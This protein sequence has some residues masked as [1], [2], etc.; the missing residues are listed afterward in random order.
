MVTGSDT[1]AFDV[2]VIGGGSAGYA[3]ARATAE[4]ALKTVVIDGGPQLGG[5]CILR[6]C[7]PTKAL[8]YASEVKHLAEH[9][10]NW[11]LQVPRVGF[12]FK[13]VMERKNALIEDFASYRRD[14]LQQG[15]FELIRSKARFMDPNT[16]A[17][18]NG[19]TLRADSILISTGSSVAPLPLPALTAAAPWTS[20]EVLN[21]SRLPESI[22]VLGGGPVALEL[23]QFFLR[24]GVRTTL[25]QR[26]PHVLKTFDE[27]MAQPLET[28]LQEEGMQLFTHTRLMDAGIK[29]GRKFVTFEQHG[30]PQTV[31][32]EA[33]LHGL[34]RQAHVAGL[35]LH[36]AGLGN[37][38]GRIHT[39]ATMRTKVPHI[40][41]AGDCT[42][43][44]EI[45]HLAIQQGETAAHNMLH[46][47]SMK[48]MD[49]RVLVSV[50]FTDPQVAMVGLS[51]KDAKAAGLRVICSDYPFND[52]G[53]SMIME[54]MHGKV[55]LI[56]D[57][58]SGELVGAACTGPIAGELIHEATVAIHQRMTAKEFA[59]VP[60]YHPT[61]AEIWTYPAEEIAEA[62]A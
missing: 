45:V 47:Q 21:L 25:I 2:A 46:P 36:K 22:I 30:K 55:K 4:A 61:L 49:Y 37:E 58:D 11:G 34:G 60:H 26:G 24:F 56:A 32:A 62:L 38:V 51:E 8:L 43:P 1:N 33:I 59:S 7:M 31:F 53:K 50:I 29:G 15:R 14:Q 6:G 17:L 5:L 19:Q 28:A 27:D 35:D 44:H 57:A 9:A 3:A 18:E 54:A 12:D 16:L 42:G 48:A 52:H 40:F 41:A 23:A 39:D 20:D 10:A 13:A